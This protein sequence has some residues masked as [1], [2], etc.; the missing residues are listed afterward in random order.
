MDDIYTHDFSTLWYNVFIQFS[1]GLI[2]HDNRVC[3]IHVPTHFEG[4]KRKCSKVLLNTEIDRTF[5]H[6]PFET[7]FTHQR[8]FV[9]G[10]LIEC[11]LICGIYII[12]NY[13]DLT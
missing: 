1:V 5:S 11:L 10:I 4:W 13:T 9:P 3:V 2:L 6:H 7:Y 8:L 12:N